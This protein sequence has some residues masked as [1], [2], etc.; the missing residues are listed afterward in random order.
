MRPMTPMTTFT[1]TASAWKPR[2]GINTMH[3]RTSQISG[4]S[5]FT[6]V[7]M[8]V[9]LTLI[10]I[11]AALA[12]TF[13]PKI[14]ERAKSQRGADLLQQWLLTARQWA[15]KAGVPTGIRLQPGQ[16]LPNRSSPNTY[17]VTDLQYIQQADPFTG[18][19]V[20]LSY[21]RTRR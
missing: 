15:K 2:G 16:T 7:E 6:L 20:P 21:T 11:L 8:L 3:K 10:L 4:R 18:G 12:V 13:V 19:A 1:A 9:V 14:T 17:Y 5:G